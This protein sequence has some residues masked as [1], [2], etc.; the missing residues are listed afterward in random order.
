M[1]LSSTDLAWGDGV[2]TE[3]SKCDETLETGDRQG[4]EQASGVSAAP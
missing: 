2:V 3:D 4:T 1:I